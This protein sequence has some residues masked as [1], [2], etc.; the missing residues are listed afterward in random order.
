[1]YGLVNDDEGL[2]RVDVFRESDELGLVH[3]G[4]TVLQRT[5]LDSVQPRLQNMT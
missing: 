4:H 3:V 2:V 1:M 5:Q